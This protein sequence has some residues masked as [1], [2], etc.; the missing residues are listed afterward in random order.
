MKYYSSFDSKV[1][2]SFFFLLMFFL[3]LSF[4]IGLINN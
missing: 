2:S 1:D 3:I 4:S